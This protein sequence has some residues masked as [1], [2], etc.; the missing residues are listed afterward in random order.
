MF[1]FGVYVGRFNPIHW[2]HEKTTDTMI[3]KHGIKNSLLILGSSEAKLSIRNFFDC[4]ERQ[5][6]INILYPNLQT[7]GLRDY[8]NDKIWL[9]KLDQIIQKFTNTEPEKI[10]FFGGCLEDVNF[11][12]KA[13]R[14][15]HIVDRFNKNPSSDENTPKICATEIR[16]ALIRGLSIERM[17]NPKLLI[18]VQETF[19][20]KKNKI[21]E[22]IK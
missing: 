19:N 22:C 21:L 15:I 17:V 1:K 14:N 7:E 10:E 11:F 5:T 3:K 12:V 8:N 2:G 16:D 4:K 9:N 13:K 6:F 20:K 18:P